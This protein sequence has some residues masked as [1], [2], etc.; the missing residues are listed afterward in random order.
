MFL[1]CSVLRGG[2]DL[3]QLGKLSLGSAVLKQSSGIDFARIYRPK[4]LFWLAVD[5]LGLEAQVRHAGVVP[6]LL[7]VLVLDCGPQRAQSR[8][9]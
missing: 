7:K 1:R 2:I 8:W 9:V 3:G 6:G 4:M 5:A